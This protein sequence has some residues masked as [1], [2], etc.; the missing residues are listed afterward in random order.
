MWHCRLELSNE[1]LVLEMQELAHSAL[2]WESK[3]A[4]ALKLG[5]SYANVQELLGCVSF[6]TRF[7]CGVEVLVGGIAWSWVGML[8]EL[9]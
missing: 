9:V 1:K 6:W 5:D 4:H 2:S 8:F 3:A 7:A